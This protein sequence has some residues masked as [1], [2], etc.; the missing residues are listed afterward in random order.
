MRIAVSDT[1]PL[2][3]VLENAMHIAEYKI[4]SEKEA[5][6]YGD[7]KIG[8]LAFALRESGAELLRVHEKDEDLEGY[9]LNLVGGER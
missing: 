8:E 3:F 1:A 4:L 9:F 5:E 6:I 7:V 2:P